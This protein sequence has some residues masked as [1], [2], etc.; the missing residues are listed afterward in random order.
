MNVIFEKADLLTDSPLFI[1][2]SDLKK[3]LLILY[4]YF[5]PQKRKLIKALN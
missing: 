2:N 1:Y 4:I 3:K 5:Q